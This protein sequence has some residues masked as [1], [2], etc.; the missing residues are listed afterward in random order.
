M[1]LGFAAQVGWLAIAI[2]LLNVVWAKGI[3]QYS[4]VGA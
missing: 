3:R 2:V 1:T 4:A